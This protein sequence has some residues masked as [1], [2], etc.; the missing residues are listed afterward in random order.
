MLTKVCPS[1]TGGAAR[2]KGELHYSLGHNVGLHIGEE[3]GSG[4]KMS[5]KMHASKRRGERPARREHEV[6]LTCPFTV[7]PSVL[8]IVPPSAKNPDACGV[9]DGGKEPLRGEAELARL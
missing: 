8:P 2:R 3:L 4:T 9:A 6:L 5:S 1:G 7:H